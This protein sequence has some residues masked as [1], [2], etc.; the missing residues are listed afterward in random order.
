MMKGDMSA[1]C[2]IGLS[3]LLA[4]LAGC[5]T[6]SNMP[7]NG[8]PLR[9]STTP[10]IQFGGATYMQLFVTRQDGDILRE[11]YLPGEA[12][13]RWTRFIE[14]RVYSGTAEGMS[15]Q[16]F[17]K[18]MDRRL[19][20]RDP[21]AESTMSFRPGGGATL[22]FGTQSGDEAAAGLSEFDAFKFSTDAKSGVLIGFHYVE[23][24]PGNTSDRDDPDTA[25]RL[26]QVEARVR[27]EI[28]ALPAYQE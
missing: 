11:Y 14:L 1:T 21:K 2:K 7:Q 15:P 20:Q 17:V 27:P 22:D 4:C 28:E 13:D 23:R 19:K 25:R 12:P 10:S 26:M 8:R 5:A 24:F 9:V 3:A 6:N 16:A 18:D